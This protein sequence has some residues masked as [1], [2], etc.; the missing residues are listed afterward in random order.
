[1][2][3]TVTS[4]QSLAR[5]TELPSLGP[6]VVEQSS[7]Q[8]CWYH[9]TKPF[10]VWQPSAAATTC[11]T[12]GKRNMRPECRPVPKPTD[13]RM[14]N[15]THQAAS[16]PASSTHQ[17]MPGSLSPQTG[18]TKSSGAMTYFAAPQAPAKGTT[19]NHVT[20]L[21]STYLTELATKSSS[22]SPASLVARMGVRRRPMSARAASRRWRSAW[23]STSFP[24]AAALPGGSSRAG[25]SLLLGTAPP[26]PSGMA[27]GA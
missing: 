15:T 3:G 7:L 23:R 6:V 27:L 13:E 17:R 12:C 25:V 18:G 16:L 19:R 26:A 8:G 2:H 21:L 24:S 20:G 1:M 22:Q 10:D 4:S 11:M 9:G 5:V 14:P